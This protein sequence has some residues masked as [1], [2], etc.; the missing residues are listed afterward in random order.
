MRKRVLLPAL[1]SI[2]MSLCIPACAQHIHSDSIQVFSDEEIAKIKSYEMTSKERVK[3]DKTITDCYIIEIGAISDQ[4]RARPAYR[5][6][7]TKKTY[8]VP[9]GITVKE[10]ILSLPG[11]KR[12]ILGR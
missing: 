5:E 3:K 11:I 9:E 7:Y 6:E 8:Q 1:A 4:N 12:N 2:M 10:L